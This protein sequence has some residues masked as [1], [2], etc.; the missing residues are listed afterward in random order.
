M[1][2]VGDE[3]DLSLHL[4]FTYVPPGG[5]ESRHA[6][7]RLLR[8]KPAALGGYPALEAAVVDLIKRAAR[9]VEQRAGGS[10]DRRQKKGPVRL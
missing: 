8:K 4:L 3:M 2:Q 7:A 5:A 1:D 9:R 6:L 10:S